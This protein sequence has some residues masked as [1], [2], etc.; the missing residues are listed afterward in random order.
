MT[1]PDR[2]R[3]PRPGLQRA[4][5]G[6]FARGHVADADSARL[7]RR[8]LIDTIRHLEPFR[9]SLT[10]IGAHAVF[11]RVQDVLPDMVMPSTKDAD[12]AVN[13]EFVAPQPVI[14]ELLAAAGLERIIDSMIPWAM[15][16][17]AIVQPSPV[18][19]RPPPIVPP[20]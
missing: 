19:P 13:P 17:T 15:T 11:A 12:L 6:D 1:G 16:N 18:R 5:V 3:R 14:L 20:A 4:A 8:L 7:S 9:E 2:I 10:V